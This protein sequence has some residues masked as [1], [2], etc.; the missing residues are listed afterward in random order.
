MESWLSYIPEKALVR[1][2]E[3]YRISCD[4]RVKGEPFP[5]KVFYIRVTTRT[6]NL[7]FALAFP[8]ALSIFLDN[9]D[10]RKRAGIS[11]V[12]AFLNGANR[13]VSIEGYTTDQGTFIDLVDHWTADVVLTL[14][15]CYELEEMFVR[16]SD[17]IQAV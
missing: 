9:M 17:F 5:G 12:S 2:L 13:M 11:G 14:P 6:T 1:Q 4:F 15:W 8:K 3:R 7:V 10:K 16:A